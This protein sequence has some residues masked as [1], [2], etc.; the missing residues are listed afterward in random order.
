MAIA[1]PAGTRIYL[2][3]KPVD[4]RK[5]FDGLAATAQQILKQDLFSGHLRKGRSK[6]RSP[7]CGFVPP[8]AHSQRGF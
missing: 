2:A 5:S 7:P 1:L 3:L 4:M 6:P 8:M